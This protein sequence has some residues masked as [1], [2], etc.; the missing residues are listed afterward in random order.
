MFL[1]TFIEDNKFNDLLSELAPIL[2]YDMLCGKTR[3]R[4]GEYEELFL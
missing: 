1:H 2:Y 4:L 3:N